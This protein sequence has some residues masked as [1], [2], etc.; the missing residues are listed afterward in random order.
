MRETDGLM[1]DSS[2]LLYPF[3]TNENSSQ[4]QQYLMSISPVNRAS[5]KAINHSI[6]AL[7]LDPWTYAPDTP[8]SSQPLP[9]P[10]TP[11]EMD[12]HLHNLRSSHSSHPGHNRWFDKP[13]TI[14]VES[15]GRA[16]ANGEHSPCD[17]LV[18]SIMGEYSVVQEIDLEAFP[19]DF[20]HRF[21]FHPPGWKRLKWVV[22]SHITA[23]CARAESR[24]RPIVQDSDDH[25]L[26]FDAYG[27]DFIKHEGKLV[28]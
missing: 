8:S 28:P 12:A 16:G 17:A 18:P 9:Q 23:E 2:L 13:Y 14:I 11:E 21:P 7:S 19:Y 15:N 26:W 5:L 22:D 20:F 4:N 25:V 6:L 3:D 1:Y 24:I 10:N 27:T